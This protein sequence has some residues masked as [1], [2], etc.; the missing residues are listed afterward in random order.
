MFQQAECELLCVNCHHNYITVFALS[1]CKALCVPG[2]R[3]QGV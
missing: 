3:Y 1:Q 2:L